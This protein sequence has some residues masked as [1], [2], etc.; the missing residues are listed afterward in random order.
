MNSPYDRYKGLKPGSQIEEELVQE[1]LPL[2]KNVVGRLA[3]SLPPHVDSE[4]LYSAGLVGLLNA[5]RNFD[6]EGGSSFESY[7]RV[8]IRGA[9][10]D[11]L[12]RLDWV[13]R[14]IHDKARKVQ[15]I[16]QR[17][18]QVKGELPTD[19]EMAHA[20]GI[21]EN[22]YE[23]LMAEI[24][25]ATFVCLDA[26]HGGEEGGD[27]SLHETITDESQEDPV[28]AASRREIAAVIEKRLESLPEMQRKVLALYYF[29]DMRLREIAEI[30][31]VTES[32][33]CQIHSQA[34]LALRN[35]LQRFPSV[36]D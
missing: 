16:M 32:R 36:A 21:T 34:I 3:M 7:A 28:A 31:G 19:S 30:F 5:V 35:Y 17:L 4:D 27:G 8:R 18:E 10:F 25:P 2:V 15:T 1:H 20:L 9:I 6:P 26:V 23:E 24:R 22:E 33:I 11:E 29:E 12:R 14:S 13:P